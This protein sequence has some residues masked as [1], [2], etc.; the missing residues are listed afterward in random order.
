[1]ATIV[2]LGNRD[3]FNHTGL[4]AEAGELSVEGYGIVAAKGKR[5][6]EVVD[7]EGKPP[8]QIAVDITDP[9]RGIWAM[10]TMSGRDPQADTKPPAWVASTDPG[11]ALI[12]SSQYGCEIREPE[13]EGE[14]GEFKTGGTAGLAAHLGLMLTLLLAVQLLAGRLSAHLKT[15]AGHDFQAK[16]MAGA[17][18][19]TA[20]AKWIGLTA[21]ATAPAA[22]D[23]ALT[24]EITTAGGGLVRAAATYAHT[25]G[26]NTYT[27]TNTFTANGSDTVPVTVAKMG[28]FDAS[29]A[30]N[31]PFATLL[32]PATATISAAGDTVTVTQTVTM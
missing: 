22:G 16:Q 5:R 29:S 24:G 18:S 19:A 9:V 26:T 10:Q 6:L 8:M 31:M 20:V 15:N 4:P 17:A 3:A 28:A 25:S 23:T 12:L 7:T 11:L 2:Y 1:M 13:H 30:G 21:D 27:L 32:T 14:R